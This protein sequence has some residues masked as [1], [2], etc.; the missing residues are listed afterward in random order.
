M[1]EMYHSIVFGLLPSVWQETLN[2]WMRF[3]SSKK[4]VFIYGLLKNQVDNFAEANKKSASFK[5]DSSYFSYDFK[6]QVGRTG[7]EPVTP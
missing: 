7:L 2:P 5:A 6:F 1:K 3:P 4:L